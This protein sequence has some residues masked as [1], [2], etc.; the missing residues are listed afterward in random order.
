M[1]KNPA[2]VILCSTVVKFQKSNY[3]FSLEHMVD[4]DMHLIQKIS[5]HL[6]KFKDV[7]L[8]NQKVD[9]SLFAV[10]VS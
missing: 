1:W 8:V 3:I 2:S 5:Y 9:Q 10:I 7:Y 6:S 4:L